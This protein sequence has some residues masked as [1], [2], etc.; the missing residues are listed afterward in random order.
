MPTKEQVEQY[1]EQ[2]KALREIAEDTRYGGEAAQALR[3]AEAF[4]RLADKLE[5]S[6]RYDRR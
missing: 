3:S 5:D 4:E 1:R 2:A 6:L